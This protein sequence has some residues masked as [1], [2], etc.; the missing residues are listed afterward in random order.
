LSYIA[1][2]RRC[3]VPRYN[4]V[5]KDP[6]SGRRRQK[7]GGKRKKDAVALQR[8]ID[9]E[10]ANGTF[11][12]YD[13]ISFSEM[14]DKWLE[15]SVSLR[16]KQTTITDYRQVVKNHLDPFFGKYLL[17]NISPR[18]VQEYISQKTKQS[19]SPRTVS[20]TVTAL[21]TIFAY[22]VRLEYVPA[23]PV[24]SAVRPRQA[25][26]EFG[27]LN[28]EQVQR[29]LNASSPGYFA[30]FAAAVMTG[31]RQGELIALRWRDT[32]LKRGLIRIEHSYH[33]LNGESEPKT[34]TSRRTVIISG[35]LI[36][37]LLDHHHKTG[38]NPDDLVF[39]NKV[40]NYIN[41]QN[42][43]TREFYPALKRA[44]LPRMRF[45][46]LRHTY[47]AILITMGENIKFIQQQLGHA[48][49][50]TTMD[51]YGHLLPEVSHEF[52]QRLD[53]FLFSGNV[54]ALPRESGDLAASRG[55]EGVDDVWT[56]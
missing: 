4:V 40:G 21:H 42:M 25:K 26:K 1:T 53:S 17:K 55:S 52:G 34:G 35:E 47:A 2:D 7:A 11:E 8:R 46:D 23:N 19:I 30:F 43:M 20:K 6:K 27:Y 15:E 28:Q 10:I 45:H 14:A 51:T 16:L 5:F 37:V 29:F 49:L 48:S 56:A 33:R 13:D 18:I 50:T 9:S 3:K 32:D 31:A 44:E 36:N 38:G 12:K 39:R 24:R 41:G 54:V 22:A